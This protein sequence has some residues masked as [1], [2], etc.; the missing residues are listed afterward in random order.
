[1]FTIKNKVCVI[2]VLLLS[3][4]GYGQVGINNPSPSATLEITAKKTGGSR[5]EGVI[6][7]RLPGDSL[8]KADQK[9]VYGRNQDGV[10]TFVTAAASPVNRVGQTIDIDARGYYYYDF[11][12]N[13]WIKVYGSASTSATVNILNCT[14]GTKTGALTNGVA[15]SDVSFRI[16]YTG[17]NGGN[18]PAQTIT[19]AGVTGLTAALPAGT[20]GSSGNLDFTVSGT[21]SGTGTAS[22]DLIFGGKTCTFTMDV[23]APATVTRLNCSGITQTAQVYHNETPTAQIVV[24]YSGGNVGETYPRQDLFAFQEP[25][26]GSYSIAL[27]AMRHAG[28]ITSSS[29]NIIYHLNNGGVGAGNYKFTISYGG[30]SCEYTLKVIR[31]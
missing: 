13:K 15:A 28:T 31:R 2:V 24:P 4:A 29:G 3:F 7:T 14:G 23:G 20:L 9:G 22:F 10:M 1:M 26:G 11:P 27:S 8:R 19:S 5:P 18:Y 25:R 17:G 21:P 12:A 16:P 6:Y 30:Q